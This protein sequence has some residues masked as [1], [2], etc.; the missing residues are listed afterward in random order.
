TTVESFGQT[1]AYDPIYVIE[2][3]QGIPFARNRAL[4]SAPPGTDLFCFLA[5]A[6]WPVDGWLDALLEPREN[7]RA[8]CVSGP[9]Q[10]V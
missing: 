1:G 3:N 2:Q 10:P 6:E 7:N 9:V 8:A 4:D 5:D